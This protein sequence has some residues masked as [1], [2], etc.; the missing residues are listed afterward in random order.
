[1]LSS[2]RNCRDKRPAERFCSCAQSAEIVV[3]SSCKFYWVPVNRE[4]VVETA[5]AGV[6][7]EAGARHG[8]F[9]ALPQQL[10]AAVP[11]NPMQ[12]QPTTERKIGTM[13]STTQ[14]CQTM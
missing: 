13:M 8:F 14:S 2:L 6:V 3:M 4:V 10:F 11:P 7:V 5:V 12:T 9:A 1:M